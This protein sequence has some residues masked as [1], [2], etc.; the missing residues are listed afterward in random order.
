MKSKAEIA[1]LDHLDEIG[2]SAK[3]RLSQVSAPTRRDEYWKYTPTASI[4]KKKYRKPIRQDEAITELDQ[5]GLK[6]KEGNL[7]GKRHDSSLRSTWGLM[8][9]KEGLSDEVGSHSTAYSPF[10]NSLSEELHDSGWW[11][12]VVQSEDLSLEIEEQFEAA[13]TIHLQRNVI[14]V[15]SGGSLS[16]KHY[17]NQKSSGIFTNVGMEII[18]EE[19]AQF[20]YM[21]FQSGHKDS[22]LIS[23]VD[24]TQGEGSQS[25]CFTFSEGGKIIRNNLNNL[26]T[27]SNINTKLFGVT[28]G[29]SESTIDHHTIV[30]HRHPHCESEELY[31]GL[32]FGKSKGVFNGKVFVRQDAQKTNAFQSN[33]NILMSN[34]A[35]VNSKPELEIYA[36][37]VKCSHGSTTGQFDDEA[38]FYLRARGIGEQQAR[39]LLVEGFLAEVTDQL[40]DDGFRENVQAAIHKA[41]VENE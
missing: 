4:L 32:F 1:F 36:D 13:D 6:F 11:I 27:G 30:D 21:V 31:K 9:Q 29:T 15:G 39:A 33:Q 38:L 37:D 22:Y 3:D 24:I 23:N 34:Q 14:R 35:T 5:L 17:I 10:F 26:H 41:I 7:I 19:N 20:N 40:E 16:V 18:L 28:L 2:L 25:M 8:G 12:R